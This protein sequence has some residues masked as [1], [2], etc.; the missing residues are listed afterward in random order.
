MRRDYSD[1]STLS[2]SL[3]S[4]S[5]FRRIAA[6]SAW[7]QNACQQMPITRSKNR[8]S[9]GFKRRSCFPSM[10]R[11]LMRLLRCCLHSEL[12]LCRIA[13]WRRRSRARAC[14][15]SRPGLRSS[16]SACEVAP[17]EIVKAPAV[18][19]IKLLRTVQPR[20]SNAARK[21]LV[22]SVA[23]FYVTCLQVQPTVDWREQHI[24]ICAAPVGLFAR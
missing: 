4:V 1:C 7:N 8:S 5:L 19:L 20:V 6:G 3:F 12:I 21:D 10:S 22:A 18:V 2:F 17:L 14:S 23:V 15:N 9:S 11:L 16:C 13:T 24:Q